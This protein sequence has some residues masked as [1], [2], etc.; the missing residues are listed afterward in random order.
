MGFGWG[1]LNVSD[2]SDE[3]GS[4]GSTILKLVVNIQGNHLD[5]VELLLT[6]QWNFQLKCTEFPYHRS[7]CQPLKKDT[8]ACSEF[9]SFNR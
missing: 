8:A 7:N 4:D 6:R 2:P 5:L 1:G 9:E 3:L